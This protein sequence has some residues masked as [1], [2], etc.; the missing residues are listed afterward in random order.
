MA[1]LKE[2]SRP[3]DNLLSDILSSGDLNPGNGGKN[4]GKSQ[5]VMNKE[6]KA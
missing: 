2:Y 5:S 4:T 3:S 1:K 6:N